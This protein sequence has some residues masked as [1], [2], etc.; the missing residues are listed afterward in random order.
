MFEPVVGAIAR[1]EVKSTLRDAMVRWI[2]E[3]AMGRLE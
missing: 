2:V 3:P 1:Q